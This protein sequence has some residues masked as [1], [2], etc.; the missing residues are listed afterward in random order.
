MKIF[1]L[2]QFDAVNEFV[3]IFEINLIISIDLSE[4]I[5]AN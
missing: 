4:I 5:F 3:W 2:Y 1:N